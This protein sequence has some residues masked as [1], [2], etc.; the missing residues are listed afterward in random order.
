[1][2]P[3]RNDAG[4]LRRRRFKF[5][6]TLTK[7]EIDLAPTKFSAKEQKQIEQANRAVAAAVE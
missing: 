6:G 2:K 5:T 3:S 4:E 1:L 7:I